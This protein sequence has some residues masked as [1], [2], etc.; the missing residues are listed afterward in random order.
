MARLGD[1]N[2]VIEVGDQGIWVTFARGVDRKAIAEFKRL[3]EEVCFPAV[4]EPIPHTLLSFHL[5][6]GGAAWRGAV[7]HQACSR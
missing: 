4:I 2:A 5:A 1:R 7:R 3:S 6:N